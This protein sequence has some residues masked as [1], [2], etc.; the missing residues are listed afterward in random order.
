MA[1]NKDTRV[2]VDW[3]TF[4][5]RGM[6]DARFA[7]RY[8]LG[9]DSDLFVQAP[10]SPLPGYQ[11]A[12]YF[13]HIY[14]CYDG[15]ENDYFQDMG[16]CVSMSGDG[17]RTFE[18]Y[19]TLKRI[20]TSTGVIL[21]GEEYSVFP[22]LFGLLYEND[23]RVSRMDLAIDDLS[24]L[25]DVPT[26]QECAKAG[27]INTRMSSI[28]GV[29]DLKNREDAGSTIYFGA[30]SSDFRIR[31]YDK[32]K[33]LGVAGPWVR[34]ELVMARKVSTAFVQKFMEG[35]TPDQEAAQSVGGM[36]FSILADKL[37]FIERDDCNISR[38]S[39]KDWW[40]EFL[41]SV[42]AQQV[43]SRV[44]ADH[45]VN[46]LSEWI[47]SQVAPALALTFKA[48]HGDW[49]REN[50]LVPGEKRWSKKYSSLW[51]DFQKKKQ[52]EL[53]LHVSAAGDAAAR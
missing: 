41:G 9:M 35:W 1:M 17:C 46:E 48:F 39:V 51:E 18:Q 6:N 5:C 29:F 30:E 16:V 22:L 36:A 4:S 10:A 13:G 31:I 27:E 50:V 15:R 34:V 7:A 42:E 21:Q 45:S 44:V 3:L 14:V 52:A 20:D 38:C 2:L 40:S 53:Q 37:N 32:A 24:G 28:K 8:F 26:L 23:C 33:Q 25:L 19:S 11:S 12:I 47:I 49:F 43:F